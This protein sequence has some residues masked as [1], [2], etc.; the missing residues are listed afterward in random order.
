MNR[1]TFFAG[2]GAGVVACVAACL[3]LRRRPDKLMTMPIGYNGDD[4]YIDL[5]E[6]YLPSEKGQI[7]FLGDSK[8][9]DRHQFY[10]D[11]TSYPVYFAGSN[12]AWTLDK[13][14]TP[15]QVG[16]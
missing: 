8:S 5:W 13:D 15:R 9:Y 16:G 6:I 4:E 12:T 10:A 14:G 11:G 2:L 1:R 3:G 7:R